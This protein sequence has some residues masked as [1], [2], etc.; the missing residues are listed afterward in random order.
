MERNSR[1]DCITKQGEE[2][3][4]FFAGNDWHGMKRLQKRRFDFKQVG[5]AVDEANQIVLMHSRKYN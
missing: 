3:Y 5:K 4:A 2:H 1:S